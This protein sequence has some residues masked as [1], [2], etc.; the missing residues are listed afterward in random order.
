MYIHALLFETPLAITESALRCLF[1]GSAT[2]VALI[3]LILGLICLNG[4]WFVHSIK[5]VRLLARECLLSFSSGI[6]LALFPCGSCFVYWNYRPEGSWNLSP[7][8]SIMGWADPRRFAA[9]SMGQGKDASNAKPEKKTTCMDTLFKYD[10]REIL[11]N[12]RAILTSLVDSG[13]AYEQLRDFH[14][15][16]DQLEMNGIRGTD[17]GRFFYR[18]KYRLSYRSINSYS[19]TCMHTHVLT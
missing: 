15:N 11:C 12:P 5:W 1:L 9:F 3:S 10:S 18:A 13:K 16:S 2:I 17:V 6:S 8:P 7:F 14:E 19:F 4:Y